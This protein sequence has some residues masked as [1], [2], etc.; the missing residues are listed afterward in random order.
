M[1]K[2]ALLF[3]TL[4][5]FCFVSAGFTF[6]QIAT[7][8]V[9]FDSAP[10]ANSQATGPIV[11]ATIRIP[12]IELDLPL[13]LGTVNNDRWPTSPNSLIYVSTSSMPGNTG[14]AIIYGHNW[15]SLLGRLDQ[16]E[17][18]HVISLGLSD[19]KVIKYVVESKQEVTP[20]ES[21]ILDQTAD[22]R[23][24]L[25]TCSGFLDSKRLVVV[26]KQVAN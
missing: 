19:G 8:S 23:L 2:L 9:A 14:N 16:L 17:P 18:G 5:V 24:T 20:H 6:W 22:S 10:V 7:P 1:P 26:A 25:Y 3:L 4:S 12:S 21:Q 13:T 15:Q 11:P